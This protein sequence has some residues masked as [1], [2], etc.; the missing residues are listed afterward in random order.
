MEYKESARSA[1]GFGAALLLSGCAGSMWVRDGTGEDE[2]RRD[3]SQCEFGARSGSAGYA[4]PYR[5]PGDPFV[6]GG[7]SDPYRQVREMNMFDQCMRAKGYN[8]V[9]AR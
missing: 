6:M 9:P 8:A 1:I 5:G 4:V 7:T 3:A 2:L